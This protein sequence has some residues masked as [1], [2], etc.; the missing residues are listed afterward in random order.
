MRC[1]VASW[2]RVAYRVPPVDAAAVGAA[3]AGRHL[4]GLGRLQAQ[5]RLELR[6]QRAV[7][8][9]FQQRG[10][11]GRVPAGPRQHPAQVLDHIRA[12]P[13]GLFLLGQRDCLLCRAGQLKLVRYRVI[14]AA[15]GL[16]VPYRRRDRRERDTE[17]T[18]EL[19]RPACVQLLRVEGAG[20]GGAGLEAGCLRELGQFALG[21][22]AAVPLLELRGAGA[23]AGGDGL[24]AGG[25]QPHHLP[26]DALDLKAMAIIMGGPVQAE[27]GGQCLFQVLGDDRVDRA[28]VLVVAVGVRGP[29][30]AVGAGPGGMGDLGMDV[31]LHV[32]VA[33]GVLQPVRHGQVRLAP[34]A[35]LPAVHPGAVRAG[36]DVARLALEVGEPGVHG[37]PDHGVDLGD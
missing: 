33:G 26:R 29:P 11:R 1:S 24:A 12:G 35:A 28:D 10:G 3:Q 18:G 30:L 20:L 31:Q 13:G 6:A 16:V 5:D 2:A 9:I 22:L 23:Q 32:A 4:G 27:P 15:R 7:G 17:G 34:L 25:E 21:W 14:C 37:L 36:A 19:V 8:E